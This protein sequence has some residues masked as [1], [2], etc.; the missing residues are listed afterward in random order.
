MRKE[1]REPVAKVPRIVEEVRRQTNPLLVGDVLA[2]TEGQEE[3]AEVQR[4]QA[5]VEIMAACGFYG[6]KLVVVRFRRTGVHY[7][8]SVLPV[9]NGGNLRVLRVLARWQG[10]G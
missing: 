10:L 3:F 5:A 1:D 8:A 7:L 2:L 6:T 9:G 4:S